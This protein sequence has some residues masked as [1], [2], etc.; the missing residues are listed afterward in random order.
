VSRNETPLGVAP[1]WGSLVAPSVAFK[2]PFQNKFPGDAQGYIMRS[3]T[4]TPHSSHAANSCTKHSL[5]AQPPTATCGSR[6]Q[7]YQTVQQLFLV[8]L[9]PWT[10]ESSKSLHRGRSPF[11]SFPM[12][13]SGDPDTT[14]EHRSD[15]DLGVCHVQLLTF[16]HESSKSGSILDLQRISSRSIRRRWVHGDGYMTSHDITLPCNS[17]CKAHDT[18]ALGSRGSG[19]FLRLPDGGGVAVQ[20][21]EM[22]AMLGMAIA[23]LWCRHAHTASAE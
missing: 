16:S 7:W 15:C 1:K 13:T 3:I 2:G 4:S 8:A 6:S 22:N 10:R 5:S 11:W 23:R 14:P 21:P 17:D 18:L 19:V 20:S 9:M 12:L